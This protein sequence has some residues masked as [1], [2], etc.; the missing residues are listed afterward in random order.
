MLAQALMQNQT[1]SHIDLS[2][3]FLTQPECAQLSEGLNSNHTVLGLH[4]IGNHCSIDSRGF[5][6]ILETS[7]DLQ[8]GLLSTRMMGSRQ[9]ARGEHCKNCWICE[10]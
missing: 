6:H 4:I 10:R 1:L 9:S 2:Y 3:N 8:Q 5:L 7:A